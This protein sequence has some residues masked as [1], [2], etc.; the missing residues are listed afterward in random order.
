VP[1]S[2]HRSPPPAQAGEDVPRTPQDTV[3]H[4]LIR[5]HYATFVAHAEATYTAPLP[6][7]VKDAFERYLA[8]GDFSQGFVRLHCDGCRRDVLVAFS[9]K[10]RGLCPSCSARRMCNTAAHVVDRILPNVPVR[11]WVLSL[12]W[13]LRG[14]AAT[15]PAVLS[16]MDRIFGEEIARMTTKLAGVAEAQTGS[17]AFGQLFGGSVNLHPHLHALCMDGVFTKVDGGVRFH[18]APPPSPAEVLEVAQRV[19]DRA[20]RWLHRH[21]HVDERAAEERGNEPTEPSALEGCLQLALAGGAF[22]ARPL[23]TKHDPDADLDRR[24]RRFSATSDG[25]DLHC[26]VRIAADDDQGRER[27]VRYCARPPL[28]LDR[29]EVQRD[30][31]IAYRL[32]APRKGRT[33]RVTQPLDFMARLAAL[34]PPPKIPQIRYHGVFASRSSWRPLVTPKPPPASPPKPCAAGTTATAP[35]PEPASP[36]SPLLMP[37]PLERA[38]FEPWVFAGGSASASATLAPWVFQGGP[39]EPAEPVVTIEPTTISVSHWKRLGDGE[40]FATSRYVDWA[41]LMKRTWHIDVMKCPACGHRLRVLA[42][43]TDLSVVRKIL[44]HLGVRST[45]L[46]RAPARDPTWEQQ[47][48][49]YEAA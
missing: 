39:A 23:E 2:S 18:E 5:E 29:I 9:C 40:V 45:P 11:Q 12:P 37:Q 34:I 1:S 28:S 47:T 26:A 4:R 17:I 7:Y 16:A 35:A 38:A 24:E 36:V 14:V 13:E 20:V 10:N 21:G 27:L 46:P 22:L 41:T 3:L 25:F 43:I 32:K 31:R 33:H 48:L 8:C 15:R 44:D 42:T 6:R 49:G 19:R 30:G